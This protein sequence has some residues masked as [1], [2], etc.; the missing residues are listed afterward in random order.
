MKQGNLFCWTVRLSWPLLGGLWGAWLGFGGY[1]QLPRNADSFAMLFASGFFGVFAGVGLI[2]GM[3]AGALIGG[4][5]ERLLRR[6][7]AGLAVALSVATVVNA[8]LLWLIVGVVQAKY[9]G[10]RPPVAVPAVTMTPELAPRNACETPP[11]AHSKARELW[12]AE[13]R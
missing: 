12:N 2:G 7:G 4:L 9:P 10:L 8:L 1:L 5:V 11:P 13:C 3:A 6:F